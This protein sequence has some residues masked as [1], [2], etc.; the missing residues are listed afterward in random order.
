MQNCGCLHFK[1]H[2]VRSC[3]VKVVLSKWQPR[4]EAPGQDGKLWTH[5]WNYVH[6]CSECEMITLEKLQALAPNDHEVRDR[7]GELR[8]LK[9][10]HLKG[11]A[12]RKQEDTEFEHQSDAEH[13]S[14]RA[15]QQRLE[16][17][18]QV[19]VEWKD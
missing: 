19:Q 7:L 8:A 12:K 14:P 6:L 4:M 18:E 11:I 5:P 15:K 10:E 17:A 3:G 13:D 16:L 1:S 2:G 9:A